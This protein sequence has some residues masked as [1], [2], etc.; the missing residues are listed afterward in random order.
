MPRGGGWEG[1][2]DMRDLKHLGA[3]RAYAADLWCVEKDVAG[4]DAFLDL[5][6]LSGRVAERVGALGYEAVD[7]SA[8]FKDAK[9]VLELA[10]PWTELAHDARNS[11]RMHVVVRTRCNS[12]PLLVQQKLEA[13]RGSCDADSPVAA[14]ALARDH[15]LTLTHAF[16]AT[17]SAEEELVQFAMKCNGLVKME[18]GGSAAQHFA[19]AA[20]AQAAA[21]TMPSAVFYQQR[22]QIDSMLSALKIDPANPAVEEVEQD[23]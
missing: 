1:Y 17:T 15:M 20:E 5:E 21:M 9:H 16:L 6:G 13:L 10:R 11:N 22:A 3:L 8:C 4:S 14:F 18:H 12:G 7:S 2:S 19:D 23:A